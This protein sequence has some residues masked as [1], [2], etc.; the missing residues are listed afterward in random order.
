M[1]IKEVAFS[2]IPRW[3]YRLDVEPYVGGAIEAR[4]YLESAHYPKQALRK[5]T[6]GHDGGIYNGPMFRRNYVG[7]PQYG[8]PFLT[9][10]TTPAPSVMLPE[11]VKEVAYQAAPVP[12]LLLVMV[13]KPVVPEEMVPLRVEY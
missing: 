2:W 3:G 12:V 10:L 8:V 5:L 11:I 13:F 6:M 9:S 1:K 4:A 7:S